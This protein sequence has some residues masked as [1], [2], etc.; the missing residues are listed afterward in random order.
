MKRCFLLII[1]IFSLLPAAINA[2]RNGL[3]GKGVQN[4]GFLSIGAGP[5]LFSG[6]VGNTSK[7][8][9]IDL[10]N[11]HAF[12]LAFR[13]LFVDGRF[14]YRL[15]LYYSA[16]DGNDKNFSM[17]ERGYAF[18]TKLIQPSLQ[19]EYSFIKGEFKNRD[20]TYGLYFRGGVEAA[21]PFVEFTGN[22]VRGGDSFEPNKVT[23]GIP[24]GFGLEFGV[25][26][27][28][29]VGI[30]GGGSVYFGD[31][32]DGIKTASSKSDD[33]LGEVLLTFSYRMFS[34]DGFAK[35][36]RCNSR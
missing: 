3:I 10:K 11:R 35:K 31:H 19:V 14:G 2:Q 36:C 28:I 15:S 22:P 4:E 32:L 20:V 5:V 1:F 13:H 26:P 6:D 21:I 24:L 30:E 9:L 27:N 25:T 12:A 18:E 23:L 17:P 29:R 7:D 34:R 16:F 33:L 8:P